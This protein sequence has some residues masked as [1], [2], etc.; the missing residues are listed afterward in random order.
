MRLHFLILA[1]LLP[2]MMAAQELTHPLS[3]VDSTDSAQP[4]FV[5]PSFDYTPLPVDVTPPIL[6]P[7][8]LP[9]F[10]ANSLKTSIAQ[11]GTAVLFRQ[12]GFSISASGAQ[13]HMPGLMGIEAGNIQLQQ[14]IGRVTIALN[15]QAHKY[16]FFNGLSRQF[17]LGGNISWQLNDRLS[18]HAFGSYYT[19]PTG[20][21]P[22]AVA[23]FLANKSYGG[24]ISY[25]HDSWGFDLGAQN[26]YNPSLR[27]W[28]MVPIVR[29]YIM[30]NDAPIGID[31]GPII[32]QLLNSAVGYRQNNPTIGPPIP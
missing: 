30:I 7:L 12:Q 32:Y 10:D 26:I 3:D 28:E 19:A 9:K 6:A 20:F 8:T 18:L 21:I 15:A 5:M 13:Q 1:L 4:A 22:P 17:G 11:P 31:L 24:F 16:G 23:G 25:D 29:P 27:H 14:N 2:V